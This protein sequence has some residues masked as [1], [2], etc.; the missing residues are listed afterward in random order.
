MLGS[1][2]HRELWPRAGVFLAKFDQTWSDYSGAYFGYSAV[3]EWGAGEDP[4]EV[5]DQIAAAARRFGEPRRR[6]RGGSGR[7]QNRSTGATR[8]PSRRR[9][10]A[11]A[12]S[13]SSCWT[14][15]RETATGRLFVGARVATLRTS[16]RTWAPRGPPCAR[17]ESSC[18]TRSK[19]HKWR[20]SDHDFWRISDQTG[21][22]EMRRRNDVFPT[23]PQCLRPIPTTL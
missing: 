14:L 5:Q 23:K 12:P 22:S 11:P 16:P 2:L 9:R 6:G 15:R 8:V 13:L 18:P 20:I 19:F 17:Q 3:P 1:I 21:W 7:T 4:D 10:N